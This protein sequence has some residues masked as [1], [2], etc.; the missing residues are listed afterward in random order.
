MSDL[1]KKWR[2]I[3]PSISEQNL[4]FLL[5]N[6]N[7]LNNHIADIDVLVNN[8]SPQICILTEIGKAVMKRIP[9]FPDYNTIL[10]EG[11]NAFGEIETIPEPTSVGAVYV[12]PDSTPPFQF[13]TKC[14]NKPF[15]IFGD[16][17]AKHTDWG[18]EGNNGSGNQIVSW[19]ELTGNEMIIPDKPTS[20]R[21]KSIIDFGLTHDATGWHTEVI[22]DGTSDHLPILL[23][24]PLCIPLT[25]VFKK[26]NWKI[27]IFFLNTVYEYWLSLVSNYD[28]QF[29]FIQFS[30]FLASL[31]G[32]C[33]TYES[34]R[35]YRPPWP[36]H[37]VALA[38]EVKALFI[39]K[40][41]QLTQQKY[42]SKRK[43]IL[44]DQNIWNFVRPT[45]HSFSPPFRGLTVNSVIMKNP[46]DIVDTL[47]NHYERHF[48]EPTPDMNN[49][50]QQKYISIYDKI[51]L[52]SNIPLDPIP[53]NEE[54][55]GPLNSEGNY[56]NKFNITNDTV[57]YSVDQFF[58]P[59]KI[60]CDPKVNEH[61]D[62]AKIIKELFK[63]IVD[64]F[65]QVNPKHNEVIGF[66]SWYIDINGNLQCITRDVKLFIYLCD[67]KHIPNMILD[68]K[69]TVVLPNNLPSQRFVIIK[70]VP[71][72]FSIDDV[73]NEIM[74]K[75]KSMY[76]ITELIGTNNGKTRYLRLD[77]TDTNEYKQLL[78]SGLICIDGQCLHVFEYLAAPRVLFC[79]MCNLPGHN[80]K[81]CNFTFDRCRRCGEDRKNR[82]HK[83][84]AISCHNCKGEH[85]STD[86]R[87]QTV[88]NYRRDLIHY[89]KQ[90]PERLPMD[91]HFFIP[92][93]YRSYGES[94]LYNRRSYPQLMTMP[95]NRNYQLTNDEWPSLPP[96]ARSTINYSNFTRSSS[97]DPIKNLQIQL[98]HLDK[99]CSI[100]EK[101]YEKINMEIKS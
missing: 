85:V 57:A 16:F 67:V 2:K 91:T 39:D 34:A 75:Y 13:F 98:N 24:S 43:W 29:F 61:K 37:L 42:E 4:L 52:L 48:A 5:Y 99:C 22:E 51:A 87:C 53:I 72:T 31:W 60:I 81:Y 50:I 8:H 64:D 77:L 73:K 74:N 100:D 56:N 46:K 41:S 15:Y 47:A 25:A 33:S 18:C 19:L 3:R 96:P 17:N 12:P 86:F 62:A 78:N 1:F 93:Q 20:R 38:R 44:K 82:D 7:S 68:A 30:E 35:Q 69:I 49:V 71:I 9:H 89:L 6:V 14:S 70:G 84:C 80:R 11:T 88:Q 27:F 63:V 66:E 95:P 83:N 90:H 40:R 92:S 97:S 10:Q 94:V 76:S 55:G 45:F 79:S 101:K 65:K 32:R 21:S 23:Q 26:T 36:S 58:P 28:E 59:I 54:R